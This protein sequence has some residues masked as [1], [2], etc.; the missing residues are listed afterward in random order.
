[1]YAM[2]WFRLKVRFMGM[3][4]SAIVP[5]LPKISR[6]CASVTFRVSFS[7]TILLLS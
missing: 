5:Y 6:M 3:V 4:T 1:M 7:T 2:P